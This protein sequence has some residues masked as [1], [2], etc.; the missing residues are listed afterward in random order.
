MGGDVSNEF[1]PSVVPGISDPLHQLALV[2]M[3][4]PLMDNLDFEELART[5]TRL[6]RSTFLFM[7]A[8]LRMRGGA[9]SLIN[10]LAVF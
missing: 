2:G 9:R 5:G 10:P 8:P 6:G 1:Y 7:A 3:G 4:M